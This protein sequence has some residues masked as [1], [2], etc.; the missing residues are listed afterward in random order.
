MTAVL[1]GI[2]LP[3]AT[4][5]LVL[6]DLIAWRVYWPAG[7]HA[8]KLVQ[9]YTDGWRVVGT[10]VLKLGLAGVCSS[11]FWFANREGTERLAQ[12]GLLVSIVVGG[13]GFVVFVV[14]FFV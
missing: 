5:A 2:V 7:R 8:A 12:L 3:L 10:V 14:G 6:L 13:V 9:A 4:V 1:G 11:W